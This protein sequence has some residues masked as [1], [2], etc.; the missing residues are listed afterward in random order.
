M[1]IQA[2]VQPIEIKTRVF[3]NRVNEAVIENEADKENAVLF[4][5]EITEYKKA[6]KKQKDE[7]S[8]DA[9]KELDEIKATFKDPEK[10]ISDAE[11][12]VRSKINCFLNQQRRKMEEEAL[13]I[14]QKAEEEAIKEAEKLESIKAGSG[15]YDAVTRKALIDAIEAKQNKIIDATAKQAEIN[16]SSANS[17]V[18]KVWS[19]R[20]VDLSKVPLKYLSLNE[21]AVRSAIKDGERNI[22]GLEIFQDCQVAVK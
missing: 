5:K 11:E 19:F 16:Q 10:F 2:L 18:R 8:A 3:L 9:K 17:V 14:R 12:I 15:E 7:L 1:D 13:A 4:L 20:V 22:D 6:I 21:T